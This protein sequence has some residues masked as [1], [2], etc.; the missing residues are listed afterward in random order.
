MPLYLS[1]AFLGRGD[2]RVL[3]VN[4]LHETDPLDEESAAGA[5]RPAEAMY[6]RRGCVAGQTRA[7]ARRDR[8]PTPVD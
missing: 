2:L 5:N 1:T 6:R 3:A 4:V 8:R 7:P